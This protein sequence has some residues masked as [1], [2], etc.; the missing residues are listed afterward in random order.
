MLARTVTVLGVTWKVRLE[1]RA[2]LNVARGGGA[3]GRR[4][5]PEAEHHG[6]IQG[7]VVHF[8]G[9]FSRHC[10]GRRQRRHGSGR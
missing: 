1:V 2:G 7:Q 9:H 5:S 8:G 3:V 6:R 10:E 4:V